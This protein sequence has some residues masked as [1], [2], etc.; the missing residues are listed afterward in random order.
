MDE[1]DF[2][3]HETELWLCAKFK[4]EWINEEYSKQISEDVFKYLC[5]ENKFTSLP[6]NVKLNIL[7]SSLNFNSEQFN[8]VSEYYK[9]LIEVILKNL[10]HLRK[11]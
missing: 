10:T 2:E 4:S 9:N 3:D 7:L 11:D 8:K 6:T 1:K 5:S